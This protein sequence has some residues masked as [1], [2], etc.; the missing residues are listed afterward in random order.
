M[1]N[2]DYTRLTPENRKAGSLKQHK[3]LAMGAE[4]N[5][6]DEID[7]FTGQKKMGKKGANIDIFNPTKNAG[8]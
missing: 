7:I 6:A 8:K 2:Q 1:K 4:V 5:F 3:S